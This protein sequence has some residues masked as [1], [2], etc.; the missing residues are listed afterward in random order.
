MDSEKNTHMRELLEAG[1]PVTDEGPFH[2]HSWWEAYKGGVKG[3]LG[4]GILGAGMGAITG[5]IA[6][7]GLSI[8]TGGLVA[9]ALPIVAGFAAAGLIY[10]VHE[11]GEVGKVAGAV[12]ASQKL[13]EKR[14]KEFEDSR[15]DEI[16]EEI[17]E[18]KSIIK[19]EPAPK[20]S[21]RAKADEIDVHQDNYRTSH[22][23]GSK[24]TGLAK[25]VFW[26]VALVG[27]AVGLIAGAILVT[28]DMTHG[29]LEHLGVANNAIVDS[30]KGIVGEKAL[31]YMTAMTA[32]GAIGASFGINR[33]LF[34]QAFDQ[35]DLWF[36]GFVSHGHARAVL[37][38]K[39]T[40][41]PQYIEEE[42][43]HKETAAPA[44]NREITNYPSHISYPE[45]ATHHRDKVLAAAK[46]ALMSMDHTK[47]APH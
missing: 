20:K 46:E 38:E 42:P 47:M 13:A 4:G 39:S 44:P 18:L 12:A 41:N 16:K 17:G 1:R 24:V 23:Q 14:M 26:K 33:D 6:V 11:F 22:F 15:F 2:H 40:G 29:L 30:L 32:L 5:G 35:T 9:M 25:F 19:G 21:A 43:Q 45:S 28:G 31:E 8:A 27:L 37:L 10:G 3:K 34:R 7:A 36:R